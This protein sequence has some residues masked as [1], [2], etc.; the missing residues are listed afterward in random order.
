MQTYRK[1]G[2]IIDGGT[3]EHTEQLAADRWLADTLAGNRSLLIV[4]TNEQA[5]RLSAQIRAQLVRL[6]RVQEAGVP[7]GRQGTIAGLGDIVQGPPQRLGP[8]RLRREPVAARSTARS[9]ASS[10]PATTAA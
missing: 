1:H 7:L 3:L 10:T 6:G 2:R 9:T 8:L 5:D 4:D